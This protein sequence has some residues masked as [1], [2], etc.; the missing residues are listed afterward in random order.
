MS[1]TIN[2]VGTYRGDA[3]RD[4]APAT[5]GE[6]GGLVAESQEG[7]AV[8]VNIDYFRP[9]PQVREIGE[10]VDR[11][12]SPKYRDIVSTQRPDGLTF[13]TALETAI[14]QLLD[15]I[16]PLVKAGDPE[17]VRAAEHW[18]EALNETISEN[19][20]SQHFDLGGAAIFSISTLGYLGAAPHVQRIADQALGL[21]Q[22]WD[23]C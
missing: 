7:N 9:V 11:A 18:N 8:I 20:R 21:W 4:G 12:I 6:A 17:A 5:L 19:A 3:A 1:D 15:I 2:E 16:S 22:A 10:K 13:D 23:G 14:M